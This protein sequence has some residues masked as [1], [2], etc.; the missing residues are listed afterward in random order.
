MPGDRIGARLHRCALADRR[1]GAEHPLRR[2]LAAEDDD[3]QRDGDRDPDGDAA[4]E[5]QRPQALPVP[6]GERVEQGGGQERGEQDERLEPHGGRGRRPRGE[7]AVAPHRR[8]LQRACHREQGDRDD[9]QRERLGHEKARVVQRRRQEDEPRGRERPAHRGD[10]A[11][12]EV[13]RHGH[14]R[15]GERL[16]QPRPLDAVAEVEPRERRSDQRRGEDAVVRGRE[17][18]QAERAV[19][20]QALPDH[21]VDHL[22]GGDPRGRERLRDGEARRGRRDD[23]PREDEQWEDGSTPSRRP[24]RRRVR[25]RHPGILPVRAVARQRSASGARFADRL[26]TA[27]LD[28][29]ES[30]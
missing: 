12:P 3:E 26:R 20:P 24:F 25:V 16:E 6:R 2:E 8:S 23:E 5:Q 18:A 28:S 30:L 22:V 17:V 13:G 19:R 1:V 29:P 15:R 27:S 7:D 21:P 10:R 4:E 9:R 14:E 11:R